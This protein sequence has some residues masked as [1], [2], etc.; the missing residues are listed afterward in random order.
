[1]TLLIIHMQQCT[2][3]LSE[4]E[5]DIRIDFDTNEYPNIF[6]SR[7]RYERIS[8]YIR[9]KRNDTNMIR[10]NICSGK[11]SNIFEYPNI[12]HTMIS[13]SKI[14]KE[15]ETFASHPAH[16]QLPSDEKC[17]VSVRLKRS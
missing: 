12:R 4:T 9:I 1:M 3:V 5:C 13:L 10:M 15:P 2:V 14:S 11:Y 8:E 7:K 16:T 17:G 6:V